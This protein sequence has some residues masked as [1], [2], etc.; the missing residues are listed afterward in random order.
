MTQEQK[1]QEQSISFGGPFK[2]TQKGA[3]EEFTGIGQGLNS[4]QH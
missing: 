4:L 1:E 3:G 2:S